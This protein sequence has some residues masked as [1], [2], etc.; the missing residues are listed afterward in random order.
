MKPKMGQEELRGAKMIPIWAKMIQ[1][2][3]KMNPRWPQGRQKEPKW[4]QDEP[5]WAKMSQEVARWLQDDPKMRPR[6]PHKSSNIVPPSKNTIHFAKVMKTVF[7]IHFNILLA[8]RE[9][10]HIVAKM[11][12][13]WAKMNQ[14]EPRGGQDDSKMIPRWSQ[15]GHVFAMCLIS[16]M[17]SS[18]LKCMKNSV[19]I[20]FGECM[21]FFEWRAIFEDSLWGSGA[22]RCL[23]LEGRLFFQKLRCL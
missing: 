20:T 2:D 9:I 12:S 5:R 3:P 21:L 23:F 10:R 15:E 17:A 6:D 16:R 22:Q 1:N 18:I 4:R 11:T 14:D 8:I 19:F 7:F 13:R